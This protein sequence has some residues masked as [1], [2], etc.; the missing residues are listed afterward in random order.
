MIYGTKSAGVVRPLAGMGWYN[1][2]SLNVNRQD[3]KTQREFMK[4]HCGFFHG[5]S[6]SRRLGVL[7]VRPALPWCL[8]SSAT[9]SDAWQG[10]NTW[11][12]KLM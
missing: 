9:E 7:A 6:I 2:A 8:G 4:I 1:A 3:A 5:N 10:R 11:N 12:A